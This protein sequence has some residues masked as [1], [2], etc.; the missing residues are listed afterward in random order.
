MGVSCADGGNVT[1]HPT[2]RSGPRGATVPTSGSVNS[3]ASVSGWQ[4]SWLRSRAPPRKRA[5]STKMRAT[6]A[7]MAKGF[8]GLFQIGDF[9]FQIG[10][11]CGGGFPGVRGG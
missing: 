9:K 10:D 11:V 2:F 6:K 3:R 1:L 8:M 7:M 4:D 5:V